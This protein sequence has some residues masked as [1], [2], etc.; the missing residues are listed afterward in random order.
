[1]LSRPTW[2]SHS[3]LLC[4]FQPSS[5]QPQSL[6]SSVHH[7]EFPPWPLPRRN[8][9]LSQFKL[10]DRRTATNVLNSRPGLPSPAPA[11]RASMCW[12]VMVRMLLLTLLARAR[13]V[14]GSPLMMELHGRLH[15]IWISTISFLW[16]MLGRYDCYPPHCP[17]WTLML[18]VVWCFFLDCGPA[19]GF[20]EWCDKP[21]ALG[22]HWHCQWIKEWFWTR[23]M[24]ASS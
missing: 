24:E 8:L 14:L 18:W 16:V 11:I 2:S 6:T 20:C 13:V 15:L 4:S 1:M 7:P 12:S 9:P 21:S 3:T 19:W 17:G 5:L 22:Y 10:L 23:G